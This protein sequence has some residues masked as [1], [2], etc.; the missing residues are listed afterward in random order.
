MATTKYR[1]KNGDEI[2]EVEEAEL[3]IDGAFDPERYA[4]QLGEGW[5][6]VYPDWYK[7]HELGIAGKQFQGFIWNPATNEVDFY[8][9]LENYQVREFQ[10][11]GCCYQQ[12]RYPEPP[13]I[14]PGQNDENE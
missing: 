9:G 3:L 7:I 6:V 2:R 14:E 5:E 4:R 13:T 12:L 8:D 10:E 1:V 11:K